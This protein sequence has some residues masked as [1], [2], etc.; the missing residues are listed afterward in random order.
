MSLPRENYDFMVDI[1]F[2]DLTVHVT[3]TRSVIHVN[4]VCG[5]VTLFFYFF[6]ARRN[7]L[8]L[9]PLRNEY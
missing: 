3:V 4:I 9:E 8:F 7:M 1:L 5:L 6:M 2:I